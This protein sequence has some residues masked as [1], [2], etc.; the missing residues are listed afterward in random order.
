MG[1]GR[2][3]ATSDAANT[4]KNAARER[5][6][7]KDL[8]NGF[9]SLQSLIPN[10]PPDTKLSKLD[11]LILATN[12]IKH[13]GALLQPSDARQVEPGCGQRQSERRQDAAAAAAA[14]ATAAPD[15][16]YLHPVKVSRQEPLSGFC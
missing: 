8:R 7:V 14:A 16:K 9:H 1:S 10:V 2:R 6:R 4:A 15:N 13:L 12:Y 11:I 3:T 5:S